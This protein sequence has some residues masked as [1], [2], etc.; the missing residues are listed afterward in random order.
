MSVFSVFY[1]KHCWSH[2]RF[3][4]PVRRK[5]SGAKSSGVLKGK[6]STSHPWPNGLKATKA[7]PSSFAVSIN[8]LDSWRVSKA[9][10]SAWIASIVATVIHLTSAKRF[11]VG[12][13]PQLTW[14]SLAKGCSRA[15]RKTNI[16]GFS[17]LLDLVQGRDR[18]FEWGI[19][20]DHIST[21]DWQ[22]TQET[23]ST[24]INSVEVIEVRCEAEPLDST[25]DIFLNMRGR[26]GD[27]TFCAKDF[28]ST[29]RSDYQRES[30][31]ATYMTRWLDGHTYGRPCHEHC[32]F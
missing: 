24:W 4:L 2:K 11:L 13:K 17:S 12:E 16:L 7:M 9:E 18:L 10:Y 5:S 25:L 29:F 14:I 28:E 3:S 30:L 15:L 22:H 1:L 20:G 26:V 31:L 19:Y 32:A 27:F 8:P 23:S 6:L 21:R